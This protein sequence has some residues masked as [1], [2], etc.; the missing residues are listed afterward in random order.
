MELPKC[1]KIICDGNVGMPKTAP[2]IVWGSPQ[3]RPSAPE[4]ELKPPT[5]FKEA[6]CNICMSSLA[7]HHTLS[8][9][10]LITF[11]LYEKTCK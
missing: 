2:N 1:N 6:Q 8:K 5:A 10:E 11:K 4:E 9:R 3:N 7:T